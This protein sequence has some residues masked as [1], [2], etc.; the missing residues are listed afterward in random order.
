M[1][2]GTVKQS[3]GHIR[4]YSRE[5][6]GAVFRLFLPCTESAGVGAVVDEESGMIRCDETVL[7]VEDE[8]S[9]RSLV[10]EF[11]EEQGY[12]V[13]SARDGIEGL[14]V[15]GEYDGKID[16]LITDVIMPKLGGL[17]LA[18]KLRGERPG[19]LVQYMSGYSRGEIGSEDK[20]ANEGLGDQPLLQKPFRM[21]VL[22]ASVRRLLD[23]AA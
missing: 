13:L 2:Y 22:A 8:E 20:T 12:K 19:M 1:V 21:A 6:E 9:V 14:E 10:Q 4:V 7:L 3:G 11:M 23:G 5:G 18:E 16:L 17:E 15:A